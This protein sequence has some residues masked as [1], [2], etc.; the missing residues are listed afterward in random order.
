M[1]M[2]GAGRVYHYGETN[3]STVTGLR[4]RKVGGA[5]SPSGWWLVSRASPHDVEGGPSY[6]LTLTP[7]S[8]LWSNAFSKWLLGGTNIS[9]V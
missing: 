3:V 7:S 8:F 9:P 1:D 4:T 2:S 6:P 5:M